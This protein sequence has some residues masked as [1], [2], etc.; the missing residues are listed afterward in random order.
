MESL[1]K[2]LIEQGADLN[3][4]SN[5]GKTPFEL[6]EHIEKLLTVEHFFISNNCVRTYFLIYWISD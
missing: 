4:K 1:I 5:N 2:L 3:V 6:G